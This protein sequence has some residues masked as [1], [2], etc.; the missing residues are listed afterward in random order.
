[1]RRIGEAIRVI[2][3]TL[4]ALWTH[5]LTWLL[6]TIL[7]PIDRWGRILK[8]RHSLKASLYI[9]TTVLNEIRITEDIETTETNSNWLTPIHSHCHQHKVEFAIVITVASHGS[10]SVI[11]RHYNTDEWKSEEFWV[12]ESVW[13]ST[14]QMKFLAQFEDGSHPAVVV[15]RDGNVWFGVR[16]RGRDPKT[17]WCINSWGLCPHKRWAHR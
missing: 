6:A 4:L 17:T 1:M 15:E 9:G 14:E 5:I 16:L 7:K 2:G 10:Q 8:D 11:H 12:F 3:G 13:T